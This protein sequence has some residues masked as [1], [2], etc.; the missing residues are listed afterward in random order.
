MAEAAT[1]TTADTAALRRTSTWSGAC[2]RTWSSSPCPDPSGCLARSTSTGCALIG[3]PASSAAKRAMSWGGSLLS[4]EGGDDP[5]EVI[6]LD[7]DVARLRAFARPDDAPALEDVH[8]PTCLGEAD[9]ELARQHGGGSELGRHDELDRRDDEVEVVADV[10]V[11]LPPGL[12]RGGH[13]LAV[14][15]LQLLLA[16][17]DDLVD[18]RLGDPGPLDAHRLGRSHRQ[19]EPVALAHE[20]LRARLVE[21][22]PAVGEARGGEGEPARHV[23]LDQA[24]HHVDAGALGGEH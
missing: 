2:T 10:V 23:G 24:G 9:P 17:L 13:V 1:P 21:D 12:G 8:E 3:A 4:L 19:E 6:G 22:D 18:L 5:V 14:R 15:R 7:E 16:V 11:E 20:L